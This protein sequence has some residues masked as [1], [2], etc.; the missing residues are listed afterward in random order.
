MKKIMNEKD[1]NKEEKNFIKIIKGS[2]IAI[3]LTMIVPYDKMKEC[4]NM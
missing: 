2:L 3:I 1:K 4:C